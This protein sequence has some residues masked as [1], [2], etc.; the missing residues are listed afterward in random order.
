[1]RTQID[2]INKVAK[3]VGNRVGQ[4]EDFSDIQEGLERYEEYL[5]ASLAAIQTIDADVIEG[6]ANGANPRPLTEA[7]KILRNSSNGMQ[8]LL[9]YIDAF[10]D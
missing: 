1:M 7:I 2:R 3:M 8:S 10:G 5:R 4:E 6:A 9:H